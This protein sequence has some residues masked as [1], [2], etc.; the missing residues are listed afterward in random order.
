MTNI[1]TADGGAIFR[2]GLRS[3]VDRMAGVSVQAEAGDADEVLSILSSKPAINLVISEI[4][5]ARKDGLALLADLRR[6]GRSIQVLF[7]TRCPECE[8][9]FRALN[10]GARGY[11]C[12]G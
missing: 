2:K 1:L 8:Y 6:L 5:L 12:K 3:V 9:A 11:L 4:R 7:F 10:A